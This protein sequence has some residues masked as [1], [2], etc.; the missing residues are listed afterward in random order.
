M[1]VKNARFIIMLTG[2]I[3]ILANTAWIALNGG[4]IIIA[5]GPEASVESLDAGW[6]RIAFGLPNLTS[7]QAVFPWLLLAVVNLMLVLMLSVK[8]KRSYHIGLSVL[9]ISLLSVAAGGGFI[10]GMILTLIGSLGAIEEKPLGETFLGKILRAARLDSTLFEKLRTGTEGVRSAALTIVFL[11][12]LTGLGNGIYVSTA[13]RILDTTSSKVAENIL[14]RGDVMLGMPTLAI[15][16]S[17]IGVSII[18][19]L[20]LSAIMYFLSTRIAT[21]DVTFETMAYTVSLAYAPIAVQIFMPLVFYTQPVLT[22]TWPFAFFFATNIWMGIILALAVRKVADFGM[23]KA[24]G[25]TMLG[26]SIY[27]ALN[28]A[29]IEPTFP[30]QGIRFVFQPITILEAILCAGVIIGLLTGSF[31]EH[32]RPKK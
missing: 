17:Y 21:S 9:V 32:Q 27:Y 10:I 30:T 4:P 25:I 5:S 20:V 12:F 7:G 15:T 16:A 3:L 11:N 1:N 19:W 18:K 29:L 23:S 22:G 28:Y 14:I 31:A 24:F 13:Q 8:P 2:A 26:G 6:G